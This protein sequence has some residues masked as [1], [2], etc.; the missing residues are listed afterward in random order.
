MARILL[1]LSL[2]T[3][4]LA[5][6]PHAIARSTT[7][8]SVHCD[9]LRH[10]K[11]LMS[12]SGKGFGGGEATRDPEPT[13]YDPSDPK[14]KQQAIHKAESFA[15]YLAK[16]STSTQQTAATTTQS[17]S[18]RDSAP[19]A[20]TAPTQQPIPPPPTYAPGEYSGGN[21]GKSAPEIFMTGLKNLY[22]AP[23]GWL[24]GKPPP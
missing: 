21:T 15:E 19:P 8:K 16:R 22:D 18:T 5:L 17:D 1:L 24:K 23:L 10:S 2:Y 9:Q 12:G 4:T 20:Y 3:H 13:V 6:H 14:G 7:T 11:V